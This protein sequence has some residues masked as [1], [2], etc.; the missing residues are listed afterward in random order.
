MEMIPTFNQFIDAVK[1]HAIHDNNNQIDPRT[2]ADTLTNKIVVDG[3]PDATYVKI[4]ADSQTSHSVIYVMRRHDDVHYC[5]KMC[6]NYTTA[7]HE[8]IVGRVLLSLKMPEFCGMHGV[9]IEP[10]ELKHIVPDDEL[11][12]KVFVAMRYVENSCSLTDILEDSSVSDEEI[13]VMFAHVM[14]A[15]QYAYDR[16]KF[17]HYDLKTDNVLVR[18]RSTRTEKSITT[19]LDRYTFNSHYDITIIDY[20]YSSITLA[21][22]TIGMKGAEHRGIHCRPNPSHDIVRL[23]LCM[24][25]MRPSLISYV[26]KYICINLSQVSDEDFIHVLRQCIEVNDKIINIADYWNFRTAITYEDVIIK[27][28]NHLPAHALNSS[29]RILCTYLQ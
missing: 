1:S 8:T 24:I 17:T 11:S 20:E 15:M 21:N 3:V 23:S 5:L 4:I 7:V 27:L 22:K 19:R 29:S 10:R 6:N 12:S 9:V 16:F 26:R 13:M 28:M 18:K 2:N 14:A 25:F